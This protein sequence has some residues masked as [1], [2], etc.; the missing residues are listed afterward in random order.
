MLERS[1][2]VTIIILAVC[3]LSETTQTCS[4]PP[5]TIKEHVAKKDSMNSSELWYTTVSHEVKREVTVIDSN[6][7]T[8]YALISVPK[9]K[10]NVTSAEEH[11]E[12]DDVLVT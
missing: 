12:Y 10:A 9:R 3:V 5:D 1:R 2:Q 6:N 8:E 11:S 7:Q 4:N